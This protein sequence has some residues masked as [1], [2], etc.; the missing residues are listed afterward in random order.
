MS[1]G[2]GNQKKIWV[3]WP[4]VLVQHTVNHVAH[5][6]VNGLAPL[7]PCSPR[8]LAVSSQIRGARLSTCVTAV[9]LA[10]MMRYKENTALL[11]HSSCV[12]RIV[13]DTH[14]VSPR[15]SVYLC[16][17]IFH[18]AQHETWVEVLDITRRS[19]R[20]HEICFQFGNSIVEIHKG[21]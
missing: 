6:L 1:T 11:L 5:F 20:L 7:G 15:I 3:S 4:F 10:P 2:A 12:S 19:F 18:W 16:Y 8:V 17:H 9:G 14:S 13:S 21:E